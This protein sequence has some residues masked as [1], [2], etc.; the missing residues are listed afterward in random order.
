MAF[1]RIVGAW[2]ALTLAP[3]GTKNIAAAS[4]P[5]SLVEKVYI[6]TAENDFGGHSDAF[7]DAIAWHREL[8]YQRGS[9]GAHI[10]CAQYSSGL[11]ARS[12]LEKLLTS[13]AISS[14]S[15]HKEHGTCF[16]VTASP[17]EV[18]TLSESTASFGLTLFF[19]LPSVLK[20]AP[21]LLE[22]GGDDKTGTA[23]E[24]L[25]TTYGDR[26]QMT[27]NIHGLSLV[28]SPGILPAHDVSRSAEFI[29]NL[30]ESLMSGSVDLHTANFWSNPD[31]VDCHQAR[32]EGSLRAREWT[33]AAKVVHQLSSAEGPGP[34][35]IC[36][37]GDLV[38][39]HAD[40]D[41]IMLTG[42]VAASNVSST[43]SQ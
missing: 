38:V 41:H 42:E 18:A 26:V 2:L 23:S 25:Q 43:E 6:S 9:S 7:D 13:A 39:H 3:D 37:W 20:L 22:H 34:G 14:L 33:R 10:A 11:E 19:P 30:Q 16:I 29:A 12:N 5:L 15:N 35:D 8:L 21:G 24:R 28:L 40:D 31:M 32:P 1:S 17:S 36:S 27:A 4:S